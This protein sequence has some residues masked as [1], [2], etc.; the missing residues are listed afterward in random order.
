MISSVSSASSQLF[1]AMLA[2]AN[3]R[4]LGGLGSVKASQPSSRTPAVDPSNA[5]G[6]KAELTEEEQKQVQELKKRDAEV[7]RHE[8]AHKAAAGSYAR[9]G[10][11]FEFQ[12]GPDGKQY[13]VGGEV[14][15]DTSEVPGDPQATIRKMQQIRRAASAPAEPSSK[16]RQIA[17]QAAQAEA[18]A[19]TELAKQKRD[20]TQETAGDPGTTQTTIQQNSNPAASSFQVEAPQP[21]GR[22]IDVQA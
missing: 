8:A 9:G 13:A 17:A 19:R 18:Q 7:R 4:A 20:Q 3:P 21:P 10:A 6:G 15:I 5:V 1:G 2:I 11:S 16:D 22:F 12:A 14:S